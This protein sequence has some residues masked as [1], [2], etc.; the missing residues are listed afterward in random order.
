MINYQRE[1]IQMTKWLIQCNINK[2]NVDEAFKELKQVDWRQNI[3]VSVGD[4]VFI[5]VARPVMAILYKCNVVKADIV[6]D[7]ID[8]SKFVT[9]GRYTFVIFTTPSVAETLA[10]LNLTVA[11]AV[12]TAMFGLFA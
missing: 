1:T 8:D 5:Y 7:V 6:S 10:S 2:Y 4:I 11:G 9:D 12:L 3:K